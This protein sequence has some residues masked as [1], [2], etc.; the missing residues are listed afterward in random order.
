MGSMVPPVPPLPPPPVVAP[1]VLVPPDP[2]DPPVA[3]VPDPPVVVVVVVMAVPP[4]PPVSYWPRP[5]T[6]SQ[7]ES[8]AR[9]AAPHS[10]AV[11]VLYTSSIL[12]SVPR[13]TARAGRP[14]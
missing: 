12:H 13:V 7:P 2:P 8:P 1:P 4:A 5:R 14:R 11:V 3:P 10:V 6:S 9:R